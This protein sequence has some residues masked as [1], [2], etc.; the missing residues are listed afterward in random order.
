LSSPN[1]LAV[2]AALWKLYPGIRDRM[3]TEQGQIRENINI[4]VGTK[5]SAT[6]ASA[7]AYTG[8]REITI[9]Q[10]SVADNERPA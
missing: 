6:R 1:G 9:I 4:F 10:L 8:R 5:M 2:P 3:A 7:D